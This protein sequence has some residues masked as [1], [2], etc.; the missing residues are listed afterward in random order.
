[1][2]HPKA[3]TRD[4]AAVLSVALVLTFILPAGARARAPAC[5]PPSSTDLVGLWES[6][7]TSQGGIGHTLEFRADGS[8]VEATAVLVNFSYRIDGDRLILREASADD[9]KEIDSLA[10]RIEGDTWIQTSPD[11]TRL[12]K[13]RLGAAAPGRPP[14]EGVWRYRHPTGAMA[15]ERYA[16]DGRASLR[17]PMTGSTGCFQVKGDRLGLSRPPRKDLSLQFELRDGELVVT[18]S[19]KVTAYRRE[20]AGPWYDREHIDYV[21]PRR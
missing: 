19:G 4:R 2:N 9:A 16:E 3:T 10:L 7:E 21:A 5:S 15:F 6:S 14:I 11:G 18:S 13:K 17:L 1:M 12:E 20:P 8:F